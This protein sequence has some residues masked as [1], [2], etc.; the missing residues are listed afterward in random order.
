[1]I[2]IMGLRTAMSVLSIVHAAVRGQVGSIVAYS[3]AAYSILAVVTLWFTGTCLTI[4]G[5]AAEDRYRT[6]RLVSYPNPHEP[7]DG[8]DGDG[9]HSLIVASQSS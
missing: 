4:N 9:R 7:V 1:M 3:I 2:T 8:N 6:G 5:D